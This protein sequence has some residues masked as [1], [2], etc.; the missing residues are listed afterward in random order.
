[1]K[2]IKA[3]NLITLLGRVENLIETTELICED[4]KN[5]ELKEELKFTNLSQKNTNKIINKLAGE[6]LIWVN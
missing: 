1:M 3:K 4:T 5:D 6:G 2:N